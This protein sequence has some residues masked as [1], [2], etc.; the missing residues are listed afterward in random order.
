MSQYVQHLTDQLVAAFNDPSSEA[1]DT[2]ADLL[3]AG[4]DARLSRE[5]WDEI[6]QQ[7]RNQPGW[8]V[9]DCAGSCESEL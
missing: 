4:Y 1:T 6:D 5:E 3:N 9:S 8:N 2:F 7:L